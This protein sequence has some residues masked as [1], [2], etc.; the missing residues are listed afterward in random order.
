MAKKKK[1]RAEKFL[2]YFLGAIMLLSALSF[3][4]SRPPPTQ[5]DTEQ[6]QDALIQY[7]VSQFGNTSAIVSV[8]SGPSD[9]IAIPINVRLLTS[10]RLAYVVTN[11]ISGVLDTTLEYT[12]AYVF[13]RFRVTSDFTGEEDIT[14]IL[15]SE[16]GSYT[17]YRIYESEVAGMNVELIGAQ[18]L[19]EGDQAKALLFKR[20]DNGKIIGIQN[21]RI[22]PVELTPIEEVINNSTH[23]EETPDNTADS[24]QDG[25]NSTTAEELAE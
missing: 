17:L 23:F 2:A 18:D 5:Q 19:S 21:E 20:A 6:N 10:E 24:E 1:K 13:F 9:Y 14:S 15:D 7:E 4:G 8:L 25:E 3:I 16:I 12:N 22:Q 11:N